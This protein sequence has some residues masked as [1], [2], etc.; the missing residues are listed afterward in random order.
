VNELFTYVISET[1]DEFI[2]EDSLLMVDSNI[3]GYPA[4][5]S[6]T[7]TVVGLSA[8][9][10]NAANAVAN[11]ASNWTSTYTT[12]NLNSA[13]WNNWSTVSGNYALGT[14]YVK[15]S[16]DTMTGPLTINSTTNPALIVGNGNTGYIKIGDGTFSKTAGSGWILDNLRVNGS[17]WQNGITFRDGGANA[18]L[19]SAGT[20]ILSF[21][22]NITESMRLD[23]SGNLGIGTTAPAARL[24]VFGD[25]SANGAL[26]GADITLTTQ[27][28]KGLLVRTTSAA[29]SQD[30][31]HIVVR[32]INGVANVGGT[33]NLRGSGSAGEIYNGYIASSN[34]TIT[35]GGG[36]VSPM[37]RVTNG[38][39]GP[40]TGG[41]NFSVNNN[42]TVNVD[43]ANSQAAATVLRVTGSTAQTGNLTEWRNVTPATLVYIT[44][45]GA[46]NTV[47]SISSN[48]VIYASGGNS[49]QWNSAYS[50]TQTN[51]ATWSNTYTLTATNF[52]VTQPSNWAVNTLSNGVTATLP[53][54]PLTG[55][56]IGFLDAS[57]TWAVNNFVII[58]NGQPIESVAENLNC[59][60]SGYSFSLTYVGGGKGWRVY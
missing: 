43:I 12:T 57:K 29:G 35:V 18:G 47:A 58:R 5:N 1:G 49:N 6:T 28:A 60:I 55:T 32:P 33:I 59:D 45:T 10:Q 14:Q 46:F 15:L 40:Q 7:D 11:N 8:G 3:D 36:G 44:P 22:N 16:G 48:A 19:W 9:W 53:A 39:S 2:T 30:D 20:G 23:A 42:S 27:T 13:T 54:S 41:T 31:C 51:S 21:S 26:S 38:N 56:T 34:G 4:W 37:F 24:T 25:I 50:T 17:N 52:I